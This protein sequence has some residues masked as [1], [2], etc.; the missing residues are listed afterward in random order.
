MSFHKR[1][2]HTRC[3]S[4]SVN[5]ES[6]G[7]SSNPAESNAGLHVI[8]AYAGSY[9]THKFGKTRKTINEIEFE[10]VFYYV[11]EDSQKL[12]QNED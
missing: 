2:A 5:V 3:L 7:I 10:I 8:P 6:I 1:N 9:S 4:F 12:F 11:E